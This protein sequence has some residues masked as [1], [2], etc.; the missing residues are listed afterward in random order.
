M[1]LHKKPVGR[2]GHPCPRWLCFTFDNAFRRLI[3]RPARVLGPWVSEGQTAL[4]LGPGLGFFTIPLAR[5]VGRWGRVI[6]VDIQPKML[7]GVVRRAERSGMERRVRPHLCA[8]D[9][10]G[11]DGPV[12]FVLMFWMLHEVRNQARLLGELRGLLGPRGR[13][14]IVEPKL[15]VKAEAFESSLKTA[16]EAGFSLLSRTRVSL[17]RA[18]VLGPVP[19]EGS[20]PFGGG[21]AGDKA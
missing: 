4:D 15:H 1:A 11:L 21:P 12:D 18:A 10:V 2:D 20:G 17:S 8:P 7:E 6:A 13:M 14:M 9:K 16:E 19:R 3:H 5:L